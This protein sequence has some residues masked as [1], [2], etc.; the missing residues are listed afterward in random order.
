M[1]GADAVIDDAALTAFLTRGG[2]A[3]ILPRQSASAP[4]GITLE[5]VARHAGALE[6][7]AWPS[8]RGLSAS[9]LRRRTEGPAWIIGAGSETIGAQGLLRAHRRVEGNSVQNRE[10][11]TAGAEVGVLLPAE[12]PDRDARGGNRRAQARRASAFGR[13]PRLGRPSLEH[14]EVV[15]VDE[16]GLVHIAEDSLDLARGFFH[17]L[18]RLC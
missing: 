15:P 7:P 13:H 18:A 8:C 16:F 1:I 4:L 12:C 6:V 9:D 5:Q 10:Q 11:S 17:D 2:R 3:L 14:Y